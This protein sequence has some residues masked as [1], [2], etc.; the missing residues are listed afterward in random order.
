MRIENIMIDCGIPFKSMKEELYKVDTLLITHSHSDHVKEA[1][2]NSIRKE[3]PGITVFANADVAYQFPVDQ[4][5]GTKEF[6]LRRKRKILPFYGAHDVPVTGYLI[7]IKGLNVLYMT[8]TCRIELPV[9]IPLDY[10]F[11]ESNYDETKIRQQA[12]KY[13][14]RGYDPYLSSVARHLSTQRCKEFYYVNRRD[15]DSVLIE[16]HQSSRFY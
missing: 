13:E 16:L 6:K 14:R 11:L 15:K 2:L 12:K 1:T 10:I 8:D 5:I 3:F 7:F 9:E 4:V